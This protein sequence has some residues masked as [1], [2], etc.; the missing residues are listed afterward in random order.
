M[1]IYILTHP[2]DF[3]LDIPLNGTLL[4]L[5][6]KNNYISGCLNSIRVMALSRGD[7]TIKT[8]EQDYIIFSSFAPI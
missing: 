8:L 7:S 6:H 4:L 3:T 5:E 2:C 1:G